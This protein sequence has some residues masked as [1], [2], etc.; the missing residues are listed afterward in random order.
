MAVT[1]QA[2]PAAELADRAAD[3]P[4][5]IGRSLLEIAYKQAAAQLVSNESGAISDGDSSAT[6]FDRRRLTQ[7]YKHRLWKGDG[8][9][10]PWY[11]AIDTGTDLQWTDALV[12]GPGHNLAGLNIRVE[13]DSTTPSGDPWGTEIFDETIVAGT[14][15][16]LHAATMYK[17]R[18]WRISIVGA[19]T[20]E[21]TSFWLG[22]A[23]QF[24]T[25]PLFQSSAPTSRVGEAIEVRTQGGIPSRYV[26]AG[27]LLQRNLTWM[28]DQNYAGG[29][30]SDTD[31]LDDF[32]ENANALYGGNANF[33]YVDEPTT[34][35]SSSAALVR[36][37]SASHKPV[38]RR[39]GTS[40]AG[41]TFLSWD[42][43]EVGG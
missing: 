26:I 14:N 37:E 36:L 23:V 25:R 7:R 39:G 41:A 18:Y 8:A 12:I 13:A 4:V 22:K 17:A 1:S 33:W 15:V 19:S 20:P 32:F 30:F 42:I 28:I 31:G 43:L 27:A 38:L 16:F 10:N 21:A 35:P 29:F 40:G 6:G 2:I 5:V 24:P 34:S 11:I 3:C 9:G